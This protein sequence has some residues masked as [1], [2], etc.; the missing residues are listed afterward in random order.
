MV[1]KTYVRKGATDSNFLERNSKTRFF[2]SKASLPCRCK[3]CADTLNS[4]KSRSLDNFDL[5]EETGHVDVSCCT[6]LRII[7]LVTDIENISPL[8]RKKGRQCPYV[9]V[10]TIDP[11]LALRRHGALRRLAA[12]N[13]APQRTRPWF[14]HAKIAHDNRT[15]MKKKV[16]S[17]DWITRYVKYISLRGN[18]EG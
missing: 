6:V 11:P 12:S 16:M 8:I 10:R 17:S 18:S 2:F 13:S 9:H 4:K 7:N 1:K 15:R 14:F 5:V 3:S